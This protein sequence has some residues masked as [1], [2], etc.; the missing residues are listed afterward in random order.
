MW[1][2]LKWGTLGTLALI[3]F[4]F[5]EYTLPTHDVVRIVGTE[6]KRM[7][8]GSGWFWTGQD[9]GTGN[10]L[11]RDVRF[12]NA[13]RASGK[14]VVYRN[15]DTQWGWPLYF[16][17]D[18]ADLSAEAESLV[19]GES[20]PVW[21]SVRNYGWRITW[22]SIF[23]NALSM[24]PVSG[25]DVLIIPWFNIVFLGLLGILLLTLRRFFINW[26]KRRVDPVVAAVGDAVEDGY[27]AVAD[28]ASDAGEAAR[29]FGSRI[30]GWF[31]TKPPS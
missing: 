1:R 6:V 12:I 2:Y 25:P 10:N 3:V 8:V 16:K 18:G 13:I 11:S 14:T 22:F 30:L 21:V 17:F 26:R 31:R 23:P 20:A 7:D 24:K 5:F 29:G 9:S 4:L 28:G 15:E 19:S 27:A